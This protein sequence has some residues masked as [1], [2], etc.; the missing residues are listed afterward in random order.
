M[1]QRNR[2]R[3]YKVRWYML[4]PHHHR[5]KCANEQQT[6]INFAIVLFITVILHN[7]I[8]F[9]TLTAANFSSEL[10]AFFAIK[11]GPPKNSLNYKCPKEFARKNRFILWPG[12]ASNII[13]LVAQ[14]ILTDGGPPAWAVETY[15]G[16]IYESSRGKGWPAVCKSGPR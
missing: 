6:R 1:A 4:T 9:Y 16:R 5:H 15:L 10:R 3:Q 14:P 12:T 13:V 8:F 7:F 11:N 2:L